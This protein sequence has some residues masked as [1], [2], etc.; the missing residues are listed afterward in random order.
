MT[1]EQDR[2]VQA[3]HC[4]AFAGKND[5]DTSSSSI[6]TTT[7][8]LVEALGTQSA[9]LHRLSSQRLQAQRIKRPAGAEWAAQ[10][11]VPFFASV[12]TG[13]LLC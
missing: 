7:F 4:W 8:G 5:I 12:Q 11:E 1:F 6:R 9:K 10:K 3:G 2:G 13:Q